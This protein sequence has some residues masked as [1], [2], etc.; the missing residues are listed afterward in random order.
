MACC[1]LIREM[2]QRQKK[3]DD[4]NH[5]VPVLFILL[6]VLVALGGFVGLYVWLWSARAPATTTPPTT[7]QTV[8][9]TEIGFDDVPLCW[10][11]T[12]YCDGYPID[13]GGLNGTTVE[14]FVELQAYMEAL[15]Y[16]LDSD[17]GCWQRPLDKRR[18]ISDAIRCGF[19]VKYMIFSS[20]T[21][22]TNVTIPLLPYNQTSHV[23]H[24]VDIDWGDGTIDTLLQSDTALVRSHTYAAGDGTYTIR[25]AGTAH[26]LCYSEQDVDK[27]GQ[28]VDVQQWGRVVSYQLNLYDELNAGSVTVSAIDGPN[29]S[30][31]DI[32]LLFAVDGEGPTS[33]AQFAG[34]VTTFANWSLPN[35]VRGTRAFAGMDLPGVFWPTSLQDASYMYWRARFADVSAVVSNGTIH[36]CDHMFYRARILGS[37]ALSGT[38]VCDN[39]TNMFRQAQFDGDVSLSG[40]T[41]TNPDNAFLSVSFLGASTSFASANAVTGDADSLFS[42]AYWPNQ[43]DF[44]GLDFSALTGANY[45]FTGATFD[46]PIPLGMD[47]IRLPLVTSAT[48]AFAD[49]YNIGNLRDLD[50]R[51]L[52]VC[53]YLFQNAIIYDAWAPQWPL[54]NCTNSVRGMHDGM[55]FYG[56]ADMSA[57]NVSNIVDCSYFMY[58]GGQTVIEGNYTSPGTFAAC[59][60][61]NYAFGVRCVGSCPTPWNM[62]A[63]S[64][65]L[66]VSATRLFGI[67]GGSASPTTTYSNMPSLDFSQLVTCANVFYVQ[68]FGALHIGP[69]QFVPA[70]SPSMRCVGDATAMFSKIIFDGGANFTSLNTTLMTIVTDMFYTTTYG[71]PTAFPGPFSSALTANRA[72]GTTSFSADDPDMTRIAIPLATSA[73]SMF[74]ACNR[75]TAMPDLQPVS[76]T[77]GN[78]MFALATMTNT[79]GPSTLAWSFPQL[80]LASTMFSATDFGNYDFYTHTW[81]M[82][83]VQV[84][85]SFFN[86]AQNMPATINVNPWQMGNL[87]SLIGFAYGAQGAV[88]FNMSTWNTATMTFIIGGF[89][90]MDG[91]TLTG[92]GDLDTHL[93]IGIQTAFAG[94]TLTTAMDVSR[95]NTQSLVDA[96]EAFESCGG[97]ALNVSAWQLPSVTFVTNMFRSSNMDPDVSAW[98]LPSLVNADRVVEQTYLSTPERYDAVLTLFADRSPPIT[99]GIMGGPRSNALTDAV[100][101]IPTRVLR[102]YTTAGG[103]AA[104]TTLT[105]RSWTFNDAGGV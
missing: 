79:M 16:T 56:G 69:E 78:S 89:S 86:G 10:T 6:F 3:D 63:L 71:G 36:S 39:A 8:C 95:W 23:A 81:G 35:V 52:A 77:N 58:D 17:T 101:I 43:A 62:M 105:G 59:T 38:V 27:H 55:T 74:L 60:N 61:A 1:A 48:Q 11:G 41:M 30:L 91:V 82:G 70:F 29:P 45:L 15:D 85:D 96:S 103:G 66:A 4:D 24:N 64:F 93:V 87:G 50:L 72:F 12:D 68:T 54:M 92:I 13:V 88:T 9:L 73:T 98:A 100:S 83:N 20:T 33:V 51:S 97:V 21:V 67:Y 47:T 14:S 53:D 65:P 31:R 90:N 76:L 84:M 94:T 104:H 25:I 26:T 57:M 99:G 22:G 7:Y 46:G 44:S 34:R 18:T 102:N 5:C 2:R 19:P 42:F 37:F 32:S 40:L 75:V 28:L 49:S 80:F